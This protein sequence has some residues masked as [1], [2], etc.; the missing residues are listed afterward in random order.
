LY[1]H[2]VFLLYYLLK[3]FFILETKILKKN[4]KEKHFIQKFC[5][6]EGDMIWFELG[7]QSQVEITSIFF[8]GTSYFWIQNLIAMSR[9]IQNIIKLFFIKYFW[10]YKTWKSLSPAL[11]SPIDDE[12]S[13]IFIFE[14]KIHFYVKMI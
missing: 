13:V 3:A 7:G 4:F 1:L 10:N 14:L 9:A 2:Y 5:N 12:I 11:A 8:Y 6:F